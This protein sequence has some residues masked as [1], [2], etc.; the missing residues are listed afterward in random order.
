MARLSCGGLG[1]HA[2][3]VAEAV[4]RTFKDEPLAAVGEL[5]EQRRRQRSVVE[6]RAPAADSE[7]CGVGHRAGLGAFGTELRQERRSGPERQVVELLGD[8]EVG[9]APG[10]QAARQ[11]IFVGGSREELLSERESGR[12]AHAGTGGDRRQTD[13]AGVVGIPRAVRAEAPLHGVVGPQ[14]NG[15]SNSYLRGGLP[16][17][18]R[19]SDPGQFYRRSCSAAARAETV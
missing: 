10:L 12:A 7:I 8:N 5:I 19:S 16:L 11:S 14:P 1:D 17:P 13:C 15:R 9:A 2:G 6:G 4:G 3:D 18:Q